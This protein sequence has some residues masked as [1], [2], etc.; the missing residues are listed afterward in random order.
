[1]TG[2]RVPCRPLAN[3]GLKTPGRGRVQH[4]MAK[5]KCAPCGLLLLSG[6]GGAPLLPYTG[7]CCQL[8]LVPLHVM[9]RSSTWSE[10]SPSSLTPPNSAFQKKQLLEISEDAFCPLNKVFS[11]PDLAYPFSKVD[12]TTLVNSFF[13]RQQNPLDEL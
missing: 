3:S 12:K 2:V 6:S 5:K 7:R 11:S 9:S 1:M 10:S 4:V 13:P 8:P